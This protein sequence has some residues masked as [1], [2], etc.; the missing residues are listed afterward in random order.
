[1]KSSQE[2]RRLKDRRV[3]ERR[4]PLASG[5]HLHLGAVLVEDRRTTERRS[6]ERRSA[7]STP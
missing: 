1:M 5:M 6:G 2:R 4:Q 7:Q 3:K